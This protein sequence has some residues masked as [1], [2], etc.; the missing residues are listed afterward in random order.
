MELLQRVV[1]WRMCYTNKYYCPTRWI[2]LYNALRS[3]NNVQDLL[4]HY[5]D[6]LLADD[7]LPHR[8]SIPDEEP[9]EAETARVEPRDDEEDNEERVHGISQ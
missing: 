9:P 7:Y 5:V 2:G 8:V 6:K 1:T 4:N 3:I